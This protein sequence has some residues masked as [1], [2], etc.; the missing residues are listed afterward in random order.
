MNSRCGAAPHRRSPERGGAGGCEA[1]DGSRRSAP[2]CVREVPRAPITLAGSSRAA[3]TLLAPPLARA[4]PADRSTHV[5]RSS[6]PS[7]DR[8]VA[9]R[10]PCIPSTWRNHDRFCPFAPRTLRL[11]DLLRVRRESATEFEAA[12]EETLEEARA[13][14]PDL[15]GEVVA[16]VLEAY[17]PGGDSRTAERAADVAHTLRLTRAI[18]SL[19]RCIERLSEFDG[20]VHAS[21]RALEQMRVEATGPLLEAFGRCTTADSRTFHGSTLVRAAIRDGRVRVALTGMLADNPIH[22]AHYLGEHGDQEA[23]PD[24]IAAL[25]RLELLPAGQ[26]R[27]SPVR[28]D[29]RDHASDPAPSVAR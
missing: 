29:H 16:A 20:V 27:A 18:P 17:A 23:V 4:R 12:T 2:S 5:R 19:V 21:V 8:Q 9:A 25:D 15:A 1:A 22:A 3:V 10:P 7:E 24:L 11:R 13:L 6:G 14:G 28:G 26:R